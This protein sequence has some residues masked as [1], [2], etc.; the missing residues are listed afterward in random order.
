MFTVIIIAKVIAGFTCPPLIRAAKYT[1]TETEKANPNEMETME[2]VV[3]APMTDKTA[4]A[5]PVRTVAS[6]RL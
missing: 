2:A 1:A 6:V 3:S 5:D 4:S